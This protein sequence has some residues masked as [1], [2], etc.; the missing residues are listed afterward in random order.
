M[1]D[2]IREGERL[3][4]LQRE[5]LKLIQNPAWFC[6][7]MDAV[8][9]S[10]FTQVGKGQVCADLGCGNGVI[11][12]LLAGRTE[13]SHFSGL[14]LQTDIADMAR[15]SVQYNHLEEKVNIVTGDIK[16]ATSIFGAASF[17]VVT[18]NPP[19]LT[20]AHGLTN[21]AGHKALA[22]HELACTLADVIGSATG[23]LKPGGHFFMV[24]RPFR[25][26]EIICCM[27]EH[28]LEPKR[29]RLVYPFV[30]KEPNMVLIEGV[31]GGNPRI[32]V[33][34]PLIVYERENVYTPEIMRL[35]DM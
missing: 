27:K 30:D 33:E 12:I 26:A 28:K 23:L 5:G 8:L 2:L 29:M 14:E 32:T 31:R 15:R 21:E 11:P 17:D 20:Q 24:H 4:D 18:S 7:G 1:S 25:L 34:K 9:L 6:F 3:D 35:Y 19:Y 10:A 22:R 16:E 13:G